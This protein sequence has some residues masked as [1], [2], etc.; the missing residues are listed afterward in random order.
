MKRAYRN[1][2]KTK[3]VAAVTTATQTDDK[4]SNQTDSR[5]NF[6]SKRKK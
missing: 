1:I 2:L 5:V 4:P 3:K 6:L